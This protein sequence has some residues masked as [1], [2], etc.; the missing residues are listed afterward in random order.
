LVDQ[1]ASLPPSIWSI[2]GWL[3]NIARAGTTS[4]V[5]AQL[6]AIWADESGGGQANLNHCNIYRALLESLNVDM[7][8]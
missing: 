1:Y 7:A 8:S 5:R 2:G 3:Q 4:E 6:F